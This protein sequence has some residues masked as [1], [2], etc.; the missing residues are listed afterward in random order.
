MVPENTRLEEA[1]TN[2]GGDAEFGFTPVCAHVLSWK[3]RVHVLETDN[4]ER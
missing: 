4:R 3:R 1:E 2:H